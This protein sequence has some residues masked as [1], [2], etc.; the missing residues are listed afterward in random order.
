MVRLQ[1]TDSD[2]SRRQSHSKLPYSLALTVFPSLLPYRLHSVHMQDG[3]SSYMPEY[4]KHLWRIAV[5][6]SGG[7]DSSLLLK[8]AVDA[9]A[10]CDSIVYGIFMHTML[11]PAEEA[12]EAKILAD[13][14]TLTVLNKL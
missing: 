13:N 11:H 10:A 3:F 7:A 2:I 8:I 6:F 9:A 14:D 5:A 1:D 12:E 4:N